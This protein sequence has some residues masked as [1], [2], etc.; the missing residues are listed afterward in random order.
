M[1]IHASSLHDTREAMKERLS[2][3]VPDFEI[4]AKAELV[5][6]INR[7]PANIQPVAEIV[8]LTHSVRLMRSICGDASGL[9]MNVWDVTY[10]VV[11][12]LVVGYFAVRRLKKR[13]I[14]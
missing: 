6:E 11:F 9:L 1:A 8:P 4:H 13:L 10:I 5:F 2:G 7:L 12:T 14:S 3:V